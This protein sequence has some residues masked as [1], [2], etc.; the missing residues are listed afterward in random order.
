MSNASSFP[1]NLSLITRYDITRDEHNEC[2]MYGIDGH[3]GPSGNY[4]DQTWT[5]TEGHSMELLPHNSTQLS[6]LNNCAC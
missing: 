4:G 6:Q 1:I 5:V 3:L 2:E